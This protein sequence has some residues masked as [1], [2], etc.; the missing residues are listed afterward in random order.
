MHIQ[1]L[2]KGQL[3]T[4]DVRNECALNFTEFMNS[5]NH[6]IDSLELMNHM[7]STTMVTN[8]IRNSNHLA[9]VESMRGFPIPA[10][11]HIF[12]TK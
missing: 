10:V 5:W 8:S 1:C 12:K 4:M 2:I 6:F 11:V 9:C 3:I 7:L